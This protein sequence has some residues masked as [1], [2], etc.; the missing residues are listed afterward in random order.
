M[1]QA[2]FLADLADAAEDLGAHIRAIGP[3]S[4]ELYWGNDVSVTIES[5]LLSGA[6]LRSVL[7]P[8]PDPAQ[9]EPRPGV[10]VVTNPVAPIP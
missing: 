8:R 5:V 1:R 4:I 3:K 7:R 6:L 2:E 10:R 9:V